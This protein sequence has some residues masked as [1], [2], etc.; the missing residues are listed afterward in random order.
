MNDSVAS[1]PKVSVLMPVRDGERYI[2][3]AIDSILTQTLSDLELII[4]D[5][6]SVDSSP[7]IVND[8]ASRDPRIRVARNEFPEGMS[9][10]LNRAAAQASASLLAR[11]DSDDIALPDR[12]E[13]QQRWLD[14][15]QEVA[16]LG[17]AMIYID[18]RGRKMSTAVMS[19]EPNVAIREAPAIAHPTVMMRRDA[20]RAVGG[21]R[22]AFDGAEDYDLWLRIGERALM[23][24]LN[25][26]ATY[27]RSHPGQATKHSRGRGPALVTLA[28][29]LA[30]LRRSGWAD[31]IGPNDRLDEDL[32]G[33]L[34]LPQA[35]ESRL[36]ALL[37]SPDLYVDAV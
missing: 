4:V 24:N 28:R 31:P 8:Y 15:R 19:L 27:Y 9:A 21:Y 14:S 13:K 23:A 22:R 10:A 29:E 16:V 33:R 36:L 12:L 1:P 7:T 32:I 2:A 11:L 34:H 6:G 37:R 5:D 25:E 26:V 3:R 35:D 20:F 18:P 17:G 30:A